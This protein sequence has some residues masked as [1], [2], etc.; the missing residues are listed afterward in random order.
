[1]RNPTYE[2][3]IPSV[4]DDTALACR[5]Y[6]SPDLLAVRGPREARASHGMRPLTPTGVPKGAIIAHAWPK[7][8]G[9]FDDK[10]VMAAVESYLSEGW[11]VGTFNLRYI[12]SGPLWKVIPLTYHSGARPSHGKSTWRA[13]AELQDYVSFV[14]FFMYYMSGICP[15]VA[16]PRTFD[17]AF[18]IDPNLTSPHSARPPALLVLGGYSYGAM[19]VRHLPNVPLMLS[20]FS[21][22]LRTSAQAVIRERASRLA[23]ATIIDIHMGSW[24]G[25]VNTRPMPTRQG[26]SSVERSTSGEKLVSAYSNP[27]QEEMT[28]EF[29][30][31]R[32]ARVKQEHMQ[33]LGNPFI[34]KKKWSL[35]PEKHLR[36]RHVAPSEED[37]LPQVDVPPPTTQYLLISLPLGIPASL[38]TGF[39]QLIP[40]SMMAAM[41]AKFIQCHTMVTT[42]KK[43]RISKRESVEEW[44]KPLVVETPDHRNRS[45]C[46]T[47]CEYDTGHLWKDRDS[48]ESLQ[49]NIRKW[50]RG[51]SRELGMA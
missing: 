14:G 34:R 20:E 42:G 27:E 3:F 33:V 16:G 13:Q 40:E 41:D 9:S 19:L 35:W 15:P 44:A 38:A 25:I 37:F 32:R 47:N 31:V 24:T 43:D 8:G 26:S 5:I 51:T 23:T 22:P 12:R 18:P 7:L 2:F 11:T 6:R 21:K 4:Y 10:V 50:A 46:G 1:M 30:R 48:L 29:Y 49:G 45:K 17:T 39:K 36:Q 28:E